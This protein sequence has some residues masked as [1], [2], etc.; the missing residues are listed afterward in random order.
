M[1]QTLKIP[2]DTS[3]RTS[4]EIRTDATE[5]GHPSWWDGVKADA[6]LNKIES[7]QSDPRK[8][9]HPYAVYSTEDCVGIKVPNQI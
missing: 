8:G 3:W 7:E 6:E 4:A 1:G 5:A 2:T 9:E